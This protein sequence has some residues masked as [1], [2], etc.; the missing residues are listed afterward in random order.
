MFIFIGNNLGQ[1]KVSAII[2]VESYKTLYYNDGMN[3]VYKYLLEDSSGVQ[4]LNIMKDKTDSSGCFISL[5]L[6]N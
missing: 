5:K 6:C 2:V 3:V 4:A 1:G